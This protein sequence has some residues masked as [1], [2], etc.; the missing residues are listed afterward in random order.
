MIKID[1]LHNLVNGS[2]IDVR[3]S[4]GHI[5]ISS[6][7]DKMESLLEIGAIHS[8]LKLENIPH[9]CYERKSPED[10]KTKIVDCIKISLRG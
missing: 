10:Y 6:S 2:T 9:E 8:K 3:I 4:Q 5:Y 1:N 7:D